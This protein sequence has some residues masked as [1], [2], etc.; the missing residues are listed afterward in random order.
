MAQCRPAA[1]ASLKRGLSPAATGPGRERNQRKTRWDG[2]VRTWPRGSERRAG[3]G[4]KRAFYGNGAGSGLSQLCSPE[5]LFVHNHFGITWICPPPF[6]HT[7]TYKHT[8]HTQTKT[9]PATHTGLAAAG[10]RM[11]FRVAEKGFI[12]PSYL[13]G[14]VQLGGLLGGS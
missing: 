9:F 4:E 11:A 6:V 2:K 3:D 13:D 7:H 12:F 1:T 5:S 8:L 14:N 10:P